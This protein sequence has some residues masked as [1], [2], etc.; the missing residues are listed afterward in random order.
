M[1]ANEEFNINN[2]L[3]GFIP[4]IGAILLTPVFPPAPILYIAWLIWR[5]H[6]KAEREGRQWQKRE[7]D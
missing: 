2:T 6:K 4:F 7:E 3:W 1:S 5:S